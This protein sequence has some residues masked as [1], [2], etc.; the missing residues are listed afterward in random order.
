MK[1]L[2]P[3]AAAVALSFGSTAQTVKNTL[4]Y[5]QVTHLTEN[6]ANGQDWQHVISGNGN[7][8]VWYRQTSPRQV[9]VANA[10][11]SGL[12][13]IVNMGTDRLDQVDIS[14]DG[15]KIVYIGG[16]FSG[17]SRANFINAD[18]SGDVPLIALNTLHMHALKIAGDGSKAFF[19]V[20]SNSSISGGGAIERG[21][22]SINLD[23]TGLTQIA[24]P[25][26]VASALGISSSDVGVFYGGS[27]GASIDV[28]HDGSEVVFMAKN[29]TD[30]THHVFTTHN[31]ITHILGPFQWL[32]AVGISADG[33]TVAASV[34]DDGNH[35]G[36]VANYDGSNP[37]MVASNAD[38]FPFS[39][40]NSLGDAI[41]LTSDGSKVI[42]DDYGHLFN[43]DGSGVLSLA[44]ATVGGAG[45][46]MIG[47]GIAR[48]TMTTDGS[49]LLFSFSDHSTGFAQM[50]ILDVN[51][52][53]TGDCPALSDFY[54]SP[55]GAAPSGLAS[56]LRVRVTSSSTAD[57]IWYAGN[58]ALLNDLK[59][60][61]VYAGTFSDNG[62]NTG[63]Q[64][65]N[66]GIYTHNNIYASSDAE[67]G[68]R[69]MR[70]NCE[71]YDSDLR[72][73]GTAV[74]VDT[75]YVATDIG[76]HEAENSG[77]L[78][79]PNPT[80]GMVQF[81]VQGSKFKVRGVE[82][83]DALGRKVES[84]PF[85]LNSQP[86]M[87]TSNWPSG[88]YSVSLVDDEGAR[89]TERLVVEH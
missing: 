20:Y 47:D 59:D 86:M 56:E 80:N 66:D 12:T 38:M 40:G 36:W 67:L 33:S 35:E 73:Y 63:D 68:P 87:N 70:F 31:G 32:N 48:P 18:G 77:F 37:N 65:A 15:T 51:P 61:K 50:A 52:S 79:Y 58:V 88:I 28:S 85:V 23:G 17:G 45:W 5:K 1:Q 69:T 11:G 10:D 13:S 16:P 71:T 25:T 49:R 44:A 3:L 24:G 76:I 30:N 53:S 22:Y 62:V 89:H 9:Y 39:N 6:H 72:H 34:N 64:T 29:N 42:F 26:E 82:V 55:N 19:C 14:A 46:P 21:V 83:L 41:C 43:S 4:T 84:H 78:M 75:W 74:D 2:L 81:Q 54:W 57:S 8:F 7:K 27:S 60:I